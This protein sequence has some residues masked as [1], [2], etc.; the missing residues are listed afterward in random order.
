MRA[1]IF[2]VRRLTSLLKLAYVWETNVNWWRQQLILQT[3]AGEGG[4]LTERAT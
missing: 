3:N 1:I 2:S 4:D